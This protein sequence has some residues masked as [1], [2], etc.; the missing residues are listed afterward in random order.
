MSYVSLV[1]FLNAEV[2]AED[3]LLQQSVR[4]RPMSKVNIV[5]NETRESRGMSREGC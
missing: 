5:S 3:Y 4:V 1:F 2:E